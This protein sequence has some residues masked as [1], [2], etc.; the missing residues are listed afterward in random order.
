MSILVAKMF[1]ADMSGFKFVFSGD[2]C[3]KTCIY[4]A[5]MYVL[6]ML[7]NTY[8]VSKYK[9]INLLNA[10]KKNEQIKIKNPILS[11][12]IFTIGVFI[13]GYAY[14]KVTSDVKAITKAEMLLK[15][16]LM[17]IV[18][19]SFNLLVIIWIHYANYTK[20][21]RNLSKRCEYVRAE[22]AK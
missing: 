6:V 9:L 15:P 18:R 14:W 20:S 2:A 13:L 7:F 16:I 5:V 17:G 10:S 12:L 8:T 1:E 22:T 3:M 19:N 21:K 11:V 4:F